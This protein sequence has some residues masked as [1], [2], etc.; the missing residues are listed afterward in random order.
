MENF[1]GLAAIVLMF[2]IPIIAIVTHHQRKMA[3]IIHGAHRDPNNQA[4]Q[5]MYGEL[6]QTRAEVAELRDRLNSLELAKDD[7]AAR[8]AP[9]QVHLRD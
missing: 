1:V 6:Q 9:P 4:L 8:L 7:I 5:Q 2:G 3:E